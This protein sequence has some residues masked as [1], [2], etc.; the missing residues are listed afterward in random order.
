MKKI[1]AA[2]IGINM[3]L[4]A[5]SAS[6]LSFLYGKFDGDSAV[7][8][9]ND[10]GY[11]ST[12]TFETFAKGEVGTIYYFMDYVQA[13]GGQLYTPANKAWLYA[14][15]APRLSLSYLSGQKLGNAF[16]KEYYLSAQYNFG[17]NSDFRAEL[18]G[19]GVD[20]AMPGFDYFQTDLYYRL[21]DL[22]IGTTD[23]Q[24]RTFQLT[25]VYGTH[26]GSSGISFRGFTDITGFNVLSQNQ[27]LY[28]LVK[29]EGK[30]VQ[31]GVEYHYYHEFKNDFTS[32]PDVDSEAIQAMVRFNW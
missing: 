31:V 4:F 2:L 8:D 30:P 7:Y 20:L 29:I 1:I 28:D 27:L 17:G 3:S 9:T 10:K 11:K 13:A 6:S 12:L 23:Y 19:L 15:V 32:N 26:F 16:F 14:E 18:V 25:L 22:T 21:V 24:R 5:F